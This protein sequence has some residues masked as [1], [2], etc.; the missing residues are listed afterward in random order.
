MNEPFT[1]ESS[2]TV[3]ESRWTTIRRDQ[4]RMPD[5]SS[6]LRE[7]AEHLS[8]VGVVPIDGDDNVVMLRQYRHAFGDHFL[9][10]PAGVLDVADEER[11]AAVRRELVEEVALHADSVQELLTFTNSAGWTTETTTVYLATDLQPTERPADFVL[12]AEEADM[13]VVRI[14]LDEAVRM[15]HEGEIVDAKTVIGLLAAWTQLDG[16]MSS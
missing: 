12:E 5:G 14:P 6:A 15:V 7:I 3:F 2:E 4:V 13:T 9:E 16:V 11:V 10:I 1:V 8:A